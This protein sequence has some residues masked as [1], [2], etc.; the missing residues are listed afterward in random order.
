M[1]MKLNELDDI[2]RKILISLYLKVLGIQSYS[3]KLSTLE[4]IQHHGRYLIYRN[5]S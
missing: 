3:Q 2:S 1:I 5:Y 4:P